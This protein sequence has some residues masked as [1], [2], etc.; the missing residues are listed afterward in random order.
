MKLNCL[1]V[2]SFLV[3]SATFAQAPQPDT[4]VSPEIQPD[5]RAT[6]RIRAP[7]ASEVAFFG[8]WMPA[9]RQE[10][11]TKDAQGV[12]SLTLGPLPPGI[13][14]YTFTVDGLTIADPVNPRIKLR[15]RTSASLLEVPAGVPELWEP[16]DVPHGAVEINWQKT[17]VINGETREIWVYTPPGYEKSRSVRY[18]VLYLFH[19]SNDIAGGWTLAGRANL[20]LDNLLAEKKLA[21]MIVVMPY[22]HA[23]PYGSPRERQAKNTA[24]YEEYVLKDV[25][26]LI[27]SKYRVASGRRNRAIAGLSMGG[28]QALSIGLAHLDLFSAVGAFSAAV[29]ADI[30][31]A[32]ADSKGIDERLSLLWIGCGRQDSLFGRSQKL[33]ELLK[34]RGIRHT[35]RDTEGAHTY[36]VW[37]QYLGEFAPLLF[38]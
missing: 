20:I 5:R 36:T 29:P 22:G 34:A 37:R 10:K 28:G 4:L 21:P 3:A 9:G 11:M 23:V 16:R 17:K 38:R 2:A 33:S 7:Q 15:S 6:F 1:C 35:F 13:Y 8:D 26:P 30:E 14:I 25:M 27:E 19:G 32:L 24:L 12:W 31:T 18:P